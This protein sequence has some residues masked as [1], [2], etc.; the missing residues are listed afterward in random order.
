MDRLI[1]LCCTLLTVAAL[2]GCDTTSAQEHL[3]NAQTRLDEGELRTAVIELKNALQK[4]PDLAEARLL[5]GEANSRLGDHAGALKEFERALDLGL[6]NDR[7]RAGLLRSKLRLGRYHEV[8]G[9]LEGQGVLEPQFAVILG[10]AYLAGDDLERASAM[11]NQAPELAEAQQGLGLIAWRNNEIERARTHLQ[12]AVEIDPGAVEAWL[13]K[14]EFELSQQRYGAAEAAFT[15]AMDHS[16]GRVVARVGLARIHLVQGDL[17]SAGEHIAELLEVAPNLPMANYL[18]GLVKFERQDID[19]AEAAI[20]QVQ[21]VDPGHGPSLYLMGAIKYRQGQLAQAEDNLQRFLS[22]DPRN[23]SAAKLLASVRFE[24]ED[25]AGAIEALEPVRPTSEDPQLLAMYGTAQLR[26]GRPAEAA[27]ALQAAVTLAPDMAAFR[28]QLAVSLL[29]AGDQSRAEA[30]LESAIDVDGEQF[31]SDYLI[32]MLRLREQDWEGA[33]EAVEALIAKNPDSPMGY[34]LRGAVAL[35]QKDQTSAV[36]AFEAALERDPAFLPAVQNLARLH[37]RDGDRPQAIRHYQSFLEHE[38]DHSGALLALA[39][40]A[41]REGDGQAAVAYLERAVAADAAHVPSRLALA[42]VRLAENRL[43]QAGWLVDEALAQQPESPDLLLLR[44]EIDLRSG[45]PEGARRAA[46]R[47]QRQLARYADNARVHLALGELQARAG[48]PEL[49]RDNLNRAL[50]LSDGSNAQAQRTLARLELRRGN[51]DA[52]RRHL[53]SLL[54]AERPDPE[55][56]LLRADLLLAEDKRADAEPLY[57]AL[58]QEGV[59]E[60]VIRLATLDLA[61]GTADAAA[62]RLQAWLDDQPGDLGAELLLADALMRVDSD[63]ALTRYES[64]VESEN[65]VALNNLAWLYMQRGDERAVAM[66]QRAAAAAPDNADVLDTLGWVLLQDGQIDEAVTQ[67]R[68][69]V[70]LNPNNPSTQY[71]LGVALQR[72]EQPDEARAALSRALESDS[73]P[74]RQAAEQALQQVSP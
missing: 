36:D 10:G 27:E 41:M 65:P 71:H 42:R 33:A 22:E 39:E 26:L 37:E 28:N 67:L 62:A 56:R 25:F 74:E 48:Q 60:A 9:E 49:A 51:L 72:A 12:R 16:A 6:D 18:D 35:G 30:E 24:R 55:T 4:E 19:A 58:A 44:G 45:D 40:L 2:A 57:E 53:E 38:G 31:Q 7:V 5:L 69:S 21:R 70:Q 32:A 46:E 1:R 15:Q 14:G 73:F 61:S 50:E 66:A 54:A 52:A 13:R 8:I 29:A 47:L 59:R 11:Y 23:A 34:N 3:T 63:R 43:E 20:R 64:L 17:D 68:R